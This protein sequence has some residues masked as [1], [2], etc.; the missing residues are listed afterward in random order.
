MSPLWALAGA[1]FLRAHSTGDIFSSLK[2]ATYRHSRA[3]QSSY[4][5]HSRHARLPVRC[6]RCL[7]LRGQSACFPTPWPD[8]AR[9]YTYITWLHGSHGSHGSRVSSNRLVALFCGLTWFVSLAECI[10]PTRKAGRQQMGK[11]EIHVF[12]SQAMSRRPREMVH[13]LVQLWLRSGVEGFPRCWQV[14]GGPPGRCLCRF[15]R[16]SRMKLSSVPEARGPLC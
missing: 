13:G 11:R 2:P 16:Y 9:N 1:G 14:A 8:M 12:E 7:R 5:L 6:D 4:Y 15:V 10:H 3:K